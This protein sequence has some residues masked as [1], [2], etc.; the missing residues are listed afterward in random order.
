MRIVFMGTSKFA[1]PSLKT[2]IA[3]GYGIKGVVSQPDKPRGRGHKS[4]PTPVKE[5][6]LQHNLELFQTA[7]I[8]TDESIERIKQW[9]P[10]LIIVVS[11]GQIIPPAL[12]A[13]PRHGCI[14]VHASLLP[15][16]RGAAPVQRALMD[17]VKSTGVTIMFMDKGLDTGDIILQGEVAVDA[18]INHGEL[19][20]I[21]AG[22]GADLLLQAVR[23][24]AKGEK[25]PSL[26]QD[27][28]QASYA[29]RISKED[30]IINWA[31]TANSINNHIRAL[32]P[33]PGAYSCINGTKV[34][35]FAGRVINK[36]GSGVIGE[37]IKVEK[38]AFQVQTGEGILEISELQRPGKKRM[39]AS[40]FL[41]GFML[42]PGN[43]LGAEEG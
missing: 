12:L 1:L 35:I 33:Q 37:V 11:Y 27:G 10:E 2:L 43:L 7:N 13:Y 4:T 30:E 18:G 40:E 42:H 3:S 14:N 5:L 39:A 29:A 6:A 41:K 21:L 38:D 17:G 9:Q 23:R 36:A 20:E 24:L 19:E 28:S 25:L 16:Y 34:K 15:H 26:P 22:E 31:H 8:K 32:N